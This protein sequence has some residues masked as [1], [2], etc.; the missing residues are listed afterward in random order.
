M[1]KL[2]FN[3]VTIIGVGL[4]GASCALALKGRGLCETVYGYGRKEANLKQA[5][6][7]GII[8]EYS[9]EISKVC[10]H[11]DLVILSTPVG[12]FKKI[13]HEIRDS[14]KKNSLVT[15]VGSVKGP[16]VYELEELMPEGV[17]YIGSHPIAGS[18]KSGLGNARADLFDGAQ[19]II[20]PT[21]RSEKGTVRQIT[22]LWESCGGNVEIMDPMLHDQIYAA[23]S[24][25]PHLIAYALVNTVGDGNAEH[26]K[27]AGPG[28]KDTT[29]IAL[30]SPQ[31]WRDISLLN[32]N[33]LIE[34]I[35][36]FGNN[37]NIIASLIKNS[38]PAGLEHEFSK[39]RTLR[40]KC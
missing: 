21:E 22:A 1:R 3:N 24:H 4:I 5:K 40:E 30:S 33:N 25:L 39:A 28:F 20:T 6:E 13:V 34:L 26:L 10:E 12:L 38:D 9:L 37:L 19:C 16:L 7:L 23:V 14:L 11:A 32:G 36:R 2:L 8:N 29:R 18:D 17:G 15:D 31:L 35:E 27:Y